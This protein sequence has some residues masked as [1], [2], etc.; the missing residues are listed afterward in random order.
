M[1]EPREA[2]RSVQACFEEQ[3]WSYLSRRSA[4]LQQLLRCHLVPPN[5]LLEPVKVLAAPGGCS[6]QVA[7]RGGHGVHAVLNMDKNTAEATWLPED[8]HEPVKEPSGLRA[9]PAPEW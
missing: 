9:G 7:Q 8:K 6:C 4:F 5:F 2:C 3:S 1:E